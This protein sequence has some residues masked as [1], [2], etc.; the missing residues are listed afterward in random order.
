MKN[1]YF[2]E[3]FFYF[4]EFTLEVQGYLLYLEDFEQNQGR[5]PFSMI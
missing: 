2:D 4:Q 1:E 3:A 5:G